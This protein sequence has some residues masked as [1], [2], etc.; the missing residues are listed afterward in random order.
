MRSRPIRK[1]SIMLA[2]ISV[3]LGLATPLP[4]V[5]GVIEINQARAV[6]GGVTTGDT[7]GFPVT[8]SEAGSYR[9]TGNLTVPDVNTSAV[10]VTAFNVTLDLNGFSI[11]GPA[12]CSGQPVGT[13]T[14]DATGSGI[15]VEAFAQVTVKNGRVHG[16]GSHGVE[17]SF[18]RVENL[19][20]TGNGG[21]GIAAG[22][23]SVVVNNTV[24]QN[25][26]GGISAFS[27]ANLVTN[28]F[29]ERNDGIG[30]SVQNGNVTGNTVSESGGD[31]ISLNGGAA[32]DN[33]VQASLG[34]GIDGRGL[35]TGNQVS[36]NTGFG[37]NLFS[38]TAYSNN[39][40]EGN[41][42]GTVSG[43]VQSGVNVC[44]GNTTCP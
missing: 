36:G 28:N 34:D 19:T 43:G 44:N 21:V 39:L 9:L 7:P 25:R 33:V 37:L 16:M 14:C 13:F 31:G 26:Q 5:D 40:V 24:C 10:T 29:V 11:T 15:G 12:N 42:G 17:V 6:A 2:A 38:G 4:A 35:M 41:S 30:I 23:S 3:L 32:R 1:I 18:S 8:L 22:G 20:V 27:N